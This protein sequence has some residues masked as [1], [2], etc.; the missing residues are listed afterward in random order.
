M[1][2]S[3]RTVFTEK[4]EFEE[5]NRTLHCT[6]MQDIIVHKQEIGRLENLDVRK[7]MG[8]EDA[9]VMAQQNIG[10]NTFSSAS[11]KSSALFLTLKGI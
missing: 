5:P 11:F 2:E 10:A 3:F 8:P 9:T 7:A 1:H 4:E 6:G